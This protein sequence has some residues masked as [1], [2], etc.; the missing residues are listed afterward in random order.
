MKYQIL[1]RNMTRGRRGRADDGIEDVVDKLPHRTIDAS[2]AQY[3]N[4]TGSPLGRAGEFRR[5]DLRR[6]PVWGLAMM[7]RISLS[8]EK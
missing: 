6:V 1:C 8:V 3:V 7:V 5:R 2:F 4:A